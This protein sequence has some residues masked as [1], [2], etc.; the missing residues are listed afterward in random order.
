M[1]LFR[2]KRSIIVLGVVKEIIVWDKTP[3]SWSGCDSIVSA[4][5]EINR[6]QVKHCYMLKQVKLAL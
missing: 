1:T 4:R 3:L 6:E 2:Y 5:S